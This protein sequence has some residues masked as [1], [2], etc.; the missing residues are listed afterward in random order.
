[1]ALWF[2]H[3]GDGSPSVPSLP[4]VYERREPRRSGPCMPAQPE[5]DFGDERAGVET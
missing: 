5:Y 2:L 4:I 3:S 1:M